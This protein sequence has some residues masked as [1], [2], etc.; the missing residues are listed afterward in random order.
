[1]RNIAPVLDVSLFSFDSNLKP[2]VGQQVTLA[3]ASGTDVDAR[4]DLLVAQA[5]AGNSDLVVKGN[6]N[7][8]P[9]GWLCQ[10]DGTFKM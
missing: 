1:M 3:A 9:R 8:E 7:S 4:V 6:V 5:A 2:V 10:N